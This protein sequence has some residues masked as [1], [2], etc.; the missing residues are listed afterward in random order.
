MNMNSLAIASII[1]DIIATIAAVVAAIVA[2]VG[3]RSTQKDMQKSLELQG[4][5]IN[6]IVYDKRME[7]LSYYLKDIKNIDDVLEKL[8][9]RN[10]NPMEISFRMLFS[11]EL[12]KEYNDY[13]ELSDDIRRAILGMSF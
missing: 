7:V 2:I 10:K 8:L 4:R 11:V 1:I 12:I 3:N 9:P 13:M 5:V 6:T